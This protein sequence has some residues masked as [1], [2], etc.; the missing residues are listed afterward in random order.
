[1][2]MLAAERVCRALFC[3]LHRTEY[4]T[5][6]KKANARA[7][8]ALRSLSQSLASGGR[9]QLP[10]FVFVCKRTGPCR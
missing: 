7:P 4:A 6:S 9:Y 3:V 5:L 2:M 8:T 10:K 1:M